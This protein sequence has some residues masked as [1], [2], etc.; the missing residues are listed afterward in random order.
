MKVSIT[1]AKVRA[2]I[3]GSL[4]VCLAAWGDENE[5]GANRP[6]TSP[7][8]PSEWDSATCNVL[9]R[10]R[11][12][13]GRVLPGH[14]DANE[15]ERIGQA[16]ARD[17]FELEMHGRKLLARGST[18]TAVASGVKETDPEAARF[19]TEPIGDALAIATEA[20]GKYAGSASATCPGL[21]RAAEG[22]RALA[23][24]ARVG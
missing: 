3:A 12:L 6:C 5:P 1:R 24:R 16:D 21:Q 23:A 18:A 11:G 19:P 9:A 10:V 17:I 8:P 7:V 22:A 14:S 15:L 4:P 20:L 13:V 2:A